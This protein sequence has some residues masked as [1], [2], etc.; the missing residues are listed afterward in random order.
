MIIA[1]GKGKHA[2]F[3]LDFVVVPAWSIRT[4]NIIG[5]AGGATI[6]A[7]AGAVVGSIFALLALALSIFCR[8]IHC[9]PKT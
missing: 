6:M 5:R 8:R 9:C 4:Y 1:T 3:D 7:I 2:S